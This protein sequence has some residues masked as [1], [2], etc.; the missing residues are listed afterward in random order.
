MLGQGTLTEVEGST[1]LTSMYQLVKI[2]C[3]SFFTYS[4]LF[5]K[6][7]CLN[8]EVNCIAPPLQFVFHG[9]VFLGHASL[10]WA[11]LGW[12]GLGWAGLGWAGLGWAGLG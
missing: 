10:G 5:Y 3:V 6:I 8:D 12:A 9:F 1:P 11:G 4:F 2:S 7:T